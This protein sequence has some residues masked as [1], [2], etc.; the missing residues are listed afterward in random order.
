VIVRV[1]HMELAAP[2]IADPAQ[3]SHG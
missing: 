1:A 3:V 2:T